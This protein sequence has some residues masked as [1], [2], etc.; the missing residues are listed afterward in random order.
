M[1]PA[2]GQY[3]ASIGNHFIPHST[4]NNSSHQKNDEFQ[5]SRTNSFN[6]HRNAVLLK[7]PGWDKFFD[8]DP[9]NNKWISLEI[10]KNLT[11]EEIEKQGTIREFIGTEKNHCEVLILLLQCYLINIKEEKIFINDGEVNLLTEITM[12]TLIEFHLEFLTELKK[13]MDENIIV[14]EISDLILKR[15]SDETNI[16]KVLISYTEICTALE[17]TKRLYDVT[18]KKN[19]KFNSYCTRLNNDPHY[20]GRDFKSCLDLLAQRCTKYPLL[21]ERIIKLERNAELFDR[22]CSAAYV[23][24]NFT[25]TIDEN[26]KKCELNRD[27]ESIRQKI[28]KS[29]F[30]IFDGKPF[31]IQDLIF[32]EPNDPRKVVSIT[33]ALFRP[34]G[35]NSAS[36]LLIVLFDDIMVLFVLKQNNTCFFN[37][38]GHQAIFCLSKTSL[39]PI[40]RSNA[41]ALIYNCRFFMDMIT[42]DFESRSDMLSMDKTFAEAKRKLEDVDRIDDE[43]F[44]PT[45]Y[46][47]FSVANRETCFANLEDTLGLEPE[48]FKE[49]KRWWSEVE[50]LFNEKRKDDLMMI[51]HVQDSI[52]WYKKLKCQLS[53]MPFARNKEIPDKTIKRIIEMFNEINRIKIF[54]NSEYHECV[55]ELARQDCISLFDSWNS[56][57]HKNEDNEN[58]N[59][60]TLVKRVSTIN[61]EENKVGTKVQE[62][63]RHTI[64]IDSNE[65]EIVGSEAIYDLPSFAA[66][67]GDISR[68]YIEK[69]LNENIIMRDE[70]ERLRLDMVAATTQITVLKA[71]KNCDPLKHAKTLEDLRNTHVKLMD[72][73][74]EFVSKTVI[75]ENELKEKENI[76]LAKEMELK[77]KEEEL[78]LKEEEFNEKETRKLNVDSL[79]RSLDLYETDLP[80]TPNSVNPY[81]LPDAGCYADRISQKV[82]IENDCEPVFVFSKN[83]PKSESPKNDSIFAKSISKSKNFFSFNSESR[84]SLN[85]SL[86]SLHVTSRFKAGSFK[87]KKK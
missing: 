69:I 52:E 86:Q 82:D 42:I 22:A 39:R 1:A 6:R 57:F 56:I 13:R 23:M 41:V 11:Q 29:D 84:N 45:V 59:Q 60:N 37:Y 16:A 44:T 80:D 79:N 67:R 58:Y 70:L 7:M 30:G 17:E 19:A 27:W 85:A 74:T 8:W 43:D 14:R 26:L 50:K 36:K 51:K 49:Y 10:C 24:R 64:V 76:L 62:N 34:H 55:Q 21:L 12:N 5:G 54:N 20:K 48:V 25:S 9:L 65:K 18:I 46:R 87:I 61:G 75:K 78:K 66:I 33:Q 4:S 28:S 32:Q 35:S 77:K 63:R 72:L 3:V 47:R 15:F 2:I 31:S 81:N 71:Y 83:F 68:R 73:E 53:R 40:E 38:E